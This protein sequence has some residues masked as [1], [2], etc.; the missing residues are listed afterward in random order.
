MQPFF[1]IGITT[2]NRNDLLKQCLNSILSQG[3]DDFE[4]IVG[5]D[6]QA[7]E[8]NGDI[9]GINDPRIKYVNYPANLGEFNNLNE[10]MNLA[11]GHYF[12]WLA[13][14]DLMLPE[15]FSYYAQCLRECDYPMCAFAA[16]EFLKGSQSLNMN[17][18]EKMEYDLFAGDKFLY[19][20]LKRKIWPISTMGMFNREYLIDHNGFPDITK[21]PEMLGLYGEYILLI[22]SGA[23][24]KVPFI[25]QP[26]TA[27]RIH[28]ESWSEKNSEVDLIK[29]ANINFI[30]KAAQL[31]QHP[32]LHND[33]RCNIQSIMEVALYSLST[34]LYRRRTSPLAIATI[35]YRTAYYQHTEQSVLRFAM[36]RAFWLAYLKTIKNLCGKYLKKQ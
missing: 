35:L 7:A 28:N 32:T 14:D 12:S 21:Q 31:L 2:Y 15:Y 34:A 27:F 3:Y 10:L 13:D 1:S 18:P 9:L 30:R 16:F 11:T 29:A 22:Q 26:L 25:H 4:V 6:Y 24:D 36:R 20:A 17:A 23:Q 8:V 33:F 5:N 19:Q